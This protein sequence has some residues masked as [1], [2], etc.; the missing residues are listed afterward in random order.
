[1]GT[2][3]W[4]VVSSAQTNDSGNYRV[5]ATNIY[6]GVTS[7]V[8][9]VQVF[10]TP[11]NDN[12]ANAYSLGSSNRASATGYNEYATAEPGEPD[13]GGQPPAHSVWWAWTNPFPS[14]VTVDLDGSDIK[15]LLGVYA[16]ASVSNLTTIAEDASGGTNGRSRVSFMAGGG[17]VLFLAVDGQSG[18]EG[19]NLM[20][21]VSASAIASPPVITAQPLNL[22]ASPGQTVTFTNEAYG[23]PNMLIQWYGN[24]APRAG[25]TT[26]FPTATPTNYLSTLTLPDLSTNDVGLYYVVLTNDFGS[27]TSKLAALTFGSIVNGMVTDATETTTNGV[28]VGIPGVLVSVGDVSTLTDQD[29][30]YQLVGVTLGSL[31][32]DFL[33]DK[34]HAD[35]NE[36]VQ[37]WD[38]STST[39]A[40]LTATKD[41]YYD[42]VDDQFEVGQGQTVA[43]RFTMTPI[44]NG[45]RFVLTWTNVPADLD[46]LLHLPPT[47]PVPYPWIDYLPTNRGSITQPPWA[48][49]DVST[50]TGWGPD[51]ITI[52]KFYPGTYSLYANKFQGQGGAY[53]S[54]SYAQVVAY[55]GGD[56]GGPS[57]PLVP[58]GSLRVPTAG[59]NDWWHVCDIDGLTT[60][61]TWV[62]E[63]VPTPPGDSPTK[64]MV[65]PMK[66]RSR[67]ASDPPAPSRPCL[68]TNATYV[69]DFGDGS[70]V[71]N[72]FEPLHS[73]TNPG[74][75]TV[76]LRITETAG[77]PPSRTRRSRRTISTS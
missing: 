8:A 3:G 13:H 75:F 48:I 42:Y 19:T 43:Q 70:R 16:G 5:I 51:T 72:V 57:A 40:L 7:S 21:S 34:T 33:A 14:L 17:K 69:W 60:N 71:T 39:A 6:A 38:H 32:A 27:V 68:V 45:L 54:Q 41:G 10:N 56:V 36:P 2:N 9:V 52:R 73:Y 31:H 63:L 12:F 50:V 53:L 55:V 25:T 49:L 28:A 24:G 77:T 15:T 18:A 35:L 74:W 65:V 1:M 30:N 59:T 22:A 64:G 20:I 76:S 61:I 44:F 29:G 47:D 37:F 4:L 23:S 62:N 58:Y 67:A 26:T 66:G 46:L 11:G